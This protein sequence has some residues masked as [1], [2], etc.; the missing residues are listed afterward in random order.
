MWADLNDRNM[1]VGKFDE[2]FSKL[3]SL[4]LAASDSGQREK[5]RLMSEGKAARKA[6]GRNENNKD[7]FSCL[8]AFDV[9]RSCKG[10]AAV[11]ARKQV[12]QNDLV[13]FTKE[14]LTCL[15]VFAYEAFEF[16]SVE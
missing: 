4:K 12:L 13:G 9:R 7:I 1:T 2:G 5:G 8:V 11:F 6:L 14:Y 10:V 15:F 16:C 3:S